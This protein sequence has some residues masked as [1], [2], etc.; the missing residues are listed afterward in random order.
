MRAFSVVLL[1]FFSFTGMSQNQRDA[2]LQALVDD[3]LAIQDEDINYE[4]LYENLAQLL[5]NPA[6][7]NEVTAEQLR[8]FYILSERQVQAFIA[9]RAEIGSFL[10]VYELQ[11]IEG[12]TKDVYEK[13]APFITVVD[14]A[15]RLNKSLWKRIVSAPNRYVVFR[16]DRTVEEKRGYTD[17]TYAGSPERMY[18]RFRAS[19]PGDFSMGLTAEKD[20]GEKIT[21]S[22]SQRQ[23]GADFYSYHV[24]LQNKGRLKNFIIGDYQAQFGQGLVLGSAFGIGKNAEAV[25]TIRRPNVGFL[26]YTSVNEA[27]YF[28]GSAISL[29]LH[30]RVTFHAMYSSR[31]RDG[32]IALDTTRESGSSVSSFNYSGFHRTAGELA[33]RYSV[34]E[35]NLAS[36]LVYTSRSVEAGVILH[37]T[38]F[39][40]P[41]LRTARVYNQFQFAGD[42]NTNGSIFFNYTFRNFAVFSE[43]ARTLGGGS[44]TVAGIIGSYTPR[45]DMTLLYRN[46]ARDFQPLYSNALSENSVAQNERGFYWGWKYVF[47]KQYTL[48]GYI[49]LFKFPWLRYRSYAPS[50]GNEW[51]MRVTYKPSRAVSLF[52]QAR[53]ETK[54]RNLPVES[55]LYTTA[56]G[57]KRNYWINIDYAVTPG[58]SFRTRAQFSRYTIGATATKGMVVLH[59]VTWQRGKLSVSARYALFDTD[60]YDNRL[61][62]YEKDAWLAFSFPPYF[63]TGV[64]NYVVLQYSVSASVDIWLRWARVTYRD[65]TSIGSGNETIEGNERNDVKLQTRIRF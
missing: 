9:Y 2:D 37:N 64:R 11:N 3:I 58:L 19:R 47:N 8:G 32:A 25:T 38:E 54:A 27:G 49:D 20:G 35:K 56:P 65:S 48:S 33:N 62:V 10:S 46:Y 4:D 55:N 24:Q 23:Y 7:L 52:V 30:K 63:G 36:V 41:F 16:V 53:E 31:S 6:D 5:A 42:R 50:Y 14:P 22:P 60:D 59:D 29:A 57:T 12:F 44:G 34:P 17:H 13:V 21:W 43:H 45:L 18:A 28:R 61:Y 40:V 26:P 1:C 15:S 39:N 51:L